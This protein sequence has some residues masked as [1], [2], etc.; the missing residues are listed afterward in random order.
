MSDEERML[1]E[2]LL[3]D[4]WEVAAC[5]KREATDEQRARSGRCVIMGGRGR[6]ARTAYE[7]N[8]ASMSPCSRTDQ[9]QEDR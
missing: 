9:K 3:D 8:D 7:G 4:A 2:Q 1:G 6:R 5:Q